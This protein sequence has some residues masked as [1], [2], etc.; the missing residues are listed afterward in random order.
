MTNA[1]YAQP[2]PNDLIAVWIREYEAKV[3]TLNLKTK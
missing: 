2:R 1:K 3:F